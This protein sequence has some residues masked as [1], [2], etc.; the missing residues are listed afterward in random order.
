MFTRLISLVLIVAVIA[1]PMWC[2]N[3][4]CLAGQCLAGQCCATADCSLEKRS[5][6]VCPTH[7]TKNC[8]CESVPGRE[9]PEPHRCPEESSCQGICGGAVFEKT[10]EFKSIEA[11]FFVPLSA[12]DSS[13]VS[14]LARA[15]TFCS[16]HPHQLSAK[17]HG[18]FMRTL[19]SSFL[20]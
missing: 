11:S 1:C 4:Q 18:R 7:D 2:S 16:E 10:C 12:K 5:T 13:V 14:L 3:G 8:C 9:E 17:N 19:H 15:R 20:C 6:Q